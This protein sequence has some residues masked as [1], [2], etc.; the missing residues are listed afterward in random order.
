MSSSSEQI[1]IMGSVVLRTSQKIYLTCEINNLFL[2]E[3]CSLQK[4]KAVSVFA[5]PTSEWAFEY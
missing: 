2:K 1:S 5:C 4:N 3:T